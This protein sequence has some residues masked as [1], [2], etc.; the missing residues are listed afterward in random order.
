MSFIQRISRYFDINGQNSL[1][2]K[3]INE[4]PK[5][6]ST[7]MSFFIFCPN[8]QKIAVCDNI[9]SYGELIVWLPHICLSPD[10]KKRMTA[11]DGICLILSDGDSRLFAKYKEKKPFDINVS[12]V[13]LNLMQTKYGFTR[14]MC[15]T[16]LHS[17][18]PVLQCYRKTS[19][20]IWLSSEYFPKDFTDI[21]G[22]SVVYINSI[23]NNLDEMM[24]EIRI[25]QT[26]YDQRL[27]EFISNYSIDAEPVYQEHLILKYFNIEEKQIELF[28][29]DFI[30]HC[31]P[32]MS[33]TFPSF[34]TYL[35]KY[36]FVESEKCL[37]RMFYS[38]AQYY[39]RSTILIEGTLLIGLAFLDIECLPYECRIKFVFHYYDFDRDRYLS[40][41]EFREMV[42]DIDTNQSQEVIERVV[43][44][45]ML[46]NESEK[47]I[48]LHEFQFRVQH[49]W[50]EGTDRLCRF[51]F[52]FLRKILSDLENRKKSGLKKRLNQ[53]FRRLLND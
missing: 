7:C 15:F 16:R 26:I 50:L 23:Y 32:H 25:I 18:N 30:E 51:D 12:G 49:N 10:F 2:F 42:R 22:H 19:R 1:R 17:D 37:R 13:A 44:D 9:E 29:M 47:G 46:L 53:Y 52:P 28:L 39:D 24:N 21:A 6:Q 5:N 31:F 34:K 4:W 3:P 36:S 11:E 27:P 45:N 8:H 48:S 33:M 40:E 14:F 43:S 20:I 35:K 41:E 38:F